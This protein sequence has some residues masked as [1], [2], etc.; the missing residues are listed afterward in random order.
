M[1]KKNKSFD[2]IVI[3]AGPGGYVAAIRAAQLGLS[4]ACVDK[5]PELGGTCLNE[6]C[7]PSKALLQSSFKYEEALTHLSDH[8][9]DVGKPKLNL[10]KMIE[11]KNK[12]VEDLTKGISFL[13]KKNKITFVEGL[14]SFESATSLKIT[15]SDGATD[16][17]EAS[18]ILIAT[19]SVPTDLPGIEIDEKQVV[20]STGALMLDKVPDHLIVVGGGY[21]GLEMGSVWRRLGSKVTVVEYFDS[22][23]PAL[24]R[25]VA[26]SLYKSLK[27]QGIEFQLSTKVTSVKKQKKGS[28]EVHL[29]PAEGG[30]VQKVAC[31]VLLSCAG[32]KPYTDTLGLDKIGLSLTDKGFLEVNDSFETAVQG[33]Y[34]IG[35]VIGGA[36]LAHKAEEEGVAAVEGMVGQKPHINYQAIPAVIYTHPEVASVG[37]TQEQLTSEGADFNVG[38]FPFTANGRARANG[39]M[40]G[41]VK[42]LADKKTDEIYGVHILHA[43]AGTMIAEAALAL[44]Y[45]ASS[46]DIARTS[47]AHP[48]VNESMKEAALSV[49][50]RTIHV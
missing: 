39:D 50:K 48:T 9:V 37:K 20:S 29:E 7:I 49:L 36:M 8:G 44:E 26:T 38:K 31:D 4:V 18:K 16:Q 42:I 12:V 40:E 5:R 41:F 2:L 17:I 10:K 25:E 11:R 33:V 32:R 15:K 46:E 28:L 13:F 30:K 6:G 19:G 14:A 35:D 47:H 34:A 45:R 23:V 22:I 27:T 3:G 1:T 24:D 21:I 43:E